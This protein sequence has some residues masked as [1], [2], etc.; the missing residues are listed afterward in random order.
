MVF[1][2]IP[3]ISQF[4]LTTLVP[5]WFYLF[6]GLIYFAVA[7]I[8]FF[9]SYFSFRLFNVTSSKSHSVLSLS[10]LLI[11]IAF[12]MLSFVSLY[13]YQNSAALNPNI[14]N[15]NEN[16][17][18]I[19]YIFALAAYIL[20]TMINLPKKKSEFFVF[21]PLW[22][23]SSPGFL[24]T[25]ILFLFYISARSV[26]NFFKVKTEDA[27]LVMFAFL[28]ITLFHIFLLLMPFG[29]ELYL[30]AHAF[31]IVGFLSLLAML[32]RVTRK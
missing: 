26:M 31:L 27:F 32:I 24:A 2:L 8:S 19:Y 6:S 15:L 5:E 25:A 17:Y 4:P 21:V 1:N 18:N 29:I 10:F 28:M 23:I 22:F 7:A 30:A 13:T 3:V 12:G 16:T 9:I 11:G 14:F 20:L